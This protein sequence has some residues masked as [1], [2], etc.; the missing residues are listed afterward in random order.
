M[1]EQKPVNQYAERDA[2][3][4]GGH[5]IRHVCAMTKEHLHEKSDIAAE[6]AFR[7]MRIYALTKQRDELLAALEA[8]VECGIVPSSSAKEGGAAKYAR[9]VVVADKIRDAIAK[10]KC[11]AVNHFP[12]ATEMVPDGWKLV[13]VD[14]TDEMLEETCERGDYARNVWEAMLSAAHKF[15]GW[16]CSMSRCKCGSYAINHH[17]H[18]RDGSEPDLCDVCYWMERYE[19]N[20]QLLE[21]INCAKTS[22]YLSSADMLQDIRKIASRAIKD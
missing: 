16:R 12:D 9:Q 15:E 22:Q 17:L 18:G 21:Q 2:M 19:H 10:A 1:S 14:P 8:A 7:D 4:L 6:L 11:G 5:Y 20:A 13:P 3:E